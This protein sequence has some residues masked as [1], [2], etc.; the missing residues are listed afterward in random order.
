MSRD[1]V[2][3]GER[4]W[5]AAFNGGDASAV[6]ALYA[7]GA[8]LMPPNTDML[9]GRAAIEEFIKT[10]IAIGAKLEMELVDVHD[11][12]DICSSIGKYRM[13]APAGPPGTLPC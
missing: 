8:R 6:A 10:F 4:A 13:T 9:S 2:E 1:D 7:D 5:L 12:G 3:L 11:G